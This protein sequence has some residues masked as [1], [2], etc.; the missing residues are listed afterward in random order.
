MITLTRLSGSEFALN[1]DLIERADC[2][3]DTVITMIDGKK[4]VVCES[5]TEVV[6]AIR[7]HRAETIAL[8]ALVAENPHALLAGRMA[9]APAPGSAPPHLAAV[10]VLPHPAAEGDDH[11]SD[12]DEAG[13]L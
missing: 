1:S 9:P 6:A 7:A 2:T 8:S 10:A 11:D 13:E 5:L 4:Y 12:R 3:P